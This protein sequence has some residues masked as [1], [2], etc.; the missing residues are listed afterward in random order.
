MVESRLH[1]VKVGDW[2]G[3]NYGQ[4]TAHHRTHRLPCGKPCKTPRV[5]G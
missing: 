1:D 5:N 3:Q 2:I 4:I